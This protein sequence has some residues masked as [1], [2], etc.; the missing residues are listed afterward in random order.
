LKTLARRGGVVDI[1]CALDELSS[2]AETMRAQR[3]GE[4]SYLKS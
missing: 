4:F 2:S 3:F 1:D